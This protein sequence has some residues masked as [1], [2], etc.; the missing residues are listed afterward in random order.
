MLSLP[1]ELQEDIFSRDY[2]TLIQ[3]S[4]LNNACN[5]VV[6][7][8]LSRLNIDNK[9]FIKYAKKIQI[10]MAYA[11][12][13]YDKENVGL[14]ITK[15]NLLT[16]PTEKT[17]LSY[18]YLVNS[19]RIIEDDVVFGQNTYG[20]IS[21]SD[22]MLESEYDLLTSYFIYRKRLSCCSFIHNYAKK[23]T[24]KLLHT[25]HK[26]VISDYVSLLSWYL[27]L[28]ANLTRFPYELPINKY[29]NLTVHVDD[30]TLIKELQ[31]EC[32]TLY[33]VLLE[34]IDKL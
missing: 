28:R 10:N 25:R 31:Q 34:Y 29:F 33:H 27:Y 13:I 11:F 20:N 18:N 5:K 2:N 12:P 17:V 6:V 23:Q 7:H 22:I 16:L 24:L 9:E 3:C 19:I 8:I 26:N 21:L 1:L 14:N 30:T 32:D 4:F 15:L